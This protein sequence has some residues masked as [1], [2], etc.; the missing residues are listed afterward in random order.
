MNLLQLFEAESRFVIYIN[1]KPATHYATAA[2]AKKFVEFVKSKYPT[3]RLEI[4]NEMHEDTVEEHGGGVNDVDAYARWRK[5]ANKERGITKEAAAKDYA[6]TYSPK[7][8]EIGTRFCEQYGITDNIEVQL[9]V[10]IIDSI[11]ESAERTNTPLNLNTLKSEV[12][13]YFRM[14]FG[15]MGMPMPNFRKKFS[16]QGVAEGS[17]NEFATGGGDD[18]SPQ[19]Q[20]DRDSMGQSIDR[21]G[22]VSIQYYFDIFTND[23]D[24]IGYCEL[25]KGVLS[26]QLNDED[27]SVSMRD[28]SNTL[29]AQAHSLIK[30]YQSEE[31]EEGDGVAES[32]LN[33]F[34]P[35]PGFN[36]DDDDDGYP[37]VPEKFNEGDVVWITPNLPEERDHF[38]K[39]CPAIVMYS[40]ESKHGGRGDRVYPNVDLD[41]PELSD[42]DRKYYKDEARARANRPHTYALVVL[43]KDFVGEKAWYSEK[44]LTKIFRG[45]D[46]AVLCSKGDAYP[47][48]DLPADI[49]QA[50]VKALGAPGIKEQGIA[51]GTES[52]QSELAKKI[53]EL[54]AAGKDREANHLR[55]KLNNLRDRERDKQK[56]QQGVTEVEVDEWKDS[57]PGHGD[58]QDLEKVNFKKGLVSEKEEEVAHGNT[59]DEHDETNMFLKQLRMHNPQ[60]K[61]DLAALASDYRKTTQ[62]DTVE[63]GRLDQENDREDADI[64]RLDHENDHEELEINRL[65]QLLQRLK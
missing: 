17:L 14:A 57:A 28:I 65:K 63:I 24:N 19:L 47:F 50:L 4:K 32:S 31:G 37:R 44:D 52:E 61:S 25:R 39:N 35:S 38:T 43:G 48:A 53:R 16:E 46:P 45:T 59:P 51:E 12:A 13:K 1:G 49:K 40:Y 15:G 34:A 18:D 64:E 8:I 42:R 2:E 7:A 54:L 21:S 23:G 36:Y 6:G 20:L 29:V 26:G 10:E 41:D 9:V 3:A 62:K 33:E 30:Q 56:R 55:H 5:N 60:A 27:F 58:P 22:K 11:I